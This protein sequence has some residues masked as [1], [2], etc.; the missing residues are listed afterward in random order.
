MVRKKIIIGSTFVLLLILLMPSIPAVQ[1]KS[2]EEGIKQEMQ[3]KLDA[4]SFDDLEEIEDFPFIKRPML[5]GLVLL[6]GEFLHYRG[7]LLYILS[8][9]W[10]YSGWMP[11][12]VIV[13]PL[14][15]ARANFL[16]YRSMEWYDF[17]FALSKE[18]GW[19]WGF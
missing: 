16:M 6:R 19:N 4:I 11:Q 15:H 3:E 12:E 14:I 8:I 9:T 10:D 18:R 17:W 2:V 5:F 1:Q 7:A 13:F